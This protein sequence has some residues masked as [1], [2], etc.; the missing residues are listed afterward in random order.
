MPA[1]RSLIIISD[2]FAFAE[3]LASLALLQPVEGAAVAPQWSLRMHG[4]GAHPPD[5]LQ[6]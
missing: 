3:A 6:A 4:L 2:A 1:M 5:E